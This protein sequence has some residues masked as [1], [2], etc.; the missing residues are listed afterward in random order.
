[1]KKAGFVL[2]ATLLLLTSLPSFAQ[3]A[4][5]PTNPTDAYYKIVPIMKVWMHP[6]G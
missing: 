4:Y 5:S 2:A 1:M 6:L 3:Q